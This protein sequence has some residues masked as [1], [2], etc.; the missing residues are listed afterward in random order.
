MTPAKLEGNGAMAAIGNLKVK[1]QQRVI[2][3]SRGRLGYEYLV[4]WQ[5]RDDDRNFKTHLLEPFLVGEGHAPVLIAKAMRE[6]K[7]AAAL[8]GGRTRTLYETNREDPAAN[9][10]AIAEQVTGAGGHTKRPD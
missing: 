1:T 6:Y 4:E 5:D 3:L 10:L 2:A 9:H 7:K 8:G